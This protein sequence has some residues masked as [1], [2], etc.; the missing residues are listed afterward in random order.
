MSDESKRQIHP[1]RLAAFMLIGAAIAL[2]FWAPIKDDVT[3]WQNLRRLVSA[4]VGAFVGGAIELSVRPVLHRSFLE[5]RRGTWIIVTVFL[6]YPLS[7]GPAALLVKSAH[8]L[9]E[10]GQI[11]YGPLSWTSRNCRPVNDA[12]GCY[13][14]L[15]GRGTPVPNN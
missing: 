14:Q 4:V 1:V 10:P 13:L 8:W 6:I 5:T 11:V 12:L 15:W 3:G 2:C 7:I 9:A